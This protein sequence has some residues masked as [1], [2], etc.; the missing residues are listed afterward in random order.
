MEPNP[1]DFSSKKDL[2]KQ[3]E[4]P[5]RELPVPFHVY[6]EKSGVGDQIMR[7]LLDL[8][9]KPEKTEDVQKYLWV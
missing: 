5:K 7:L 6:L 9:E 8:F 4:P 3:V 2:D 1:V